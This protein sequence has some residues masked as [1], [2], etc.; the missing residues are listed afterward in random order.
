MILFQFSIDQVVLYS[1]F[2]GNF[3][4]CG[5]TRPEITHLKDALIKTGRHRPSMLLADRF[6]EL[7]S[8]EDA[9]GLYDLVMRSRQVDKFI[10]VTAGML[11]GIT[12][13]RHLSHSGN[14]KIFWRYV[15][16]KFDE[17]KFF[18]LQAKFL[19]GSLSEKEFRL[20]IGDS[21]DWKASA[22]YVIGLHHWLNGD[23]AFALQAF[24]RCL[25]VDTERKSQNRFSP[26][27][28]ARKDIERIR[29]S[30]P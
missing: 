1:T 27:K 5:A 14:A 24:E 20:R 19:N 17:F 3:K 18:S 11:V 15:E 10:R 26:Q 9:I 4:F 6:I 7:G 21:L 25:Q 23:P 29:K 12:T 30:E 8:Y 22:E 13:V 16:S 28:W 2:R